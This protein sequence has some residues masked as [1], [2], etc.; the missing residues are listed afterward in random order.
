MSRKENSGKPGTSYRGNARSL[1]PSFSRG[2]GEEEITMR[3]DNRGA[4]IT[5]A[6]SGFGRATADIM[7]REGA[8]MVAVDIGQAPLDDTV[9]ASVSWKRGTTTSSWICLDCARLP[10][11]HILLPRPATAS[12]GKY[13]S[14]AAEPPPTCWSSFEA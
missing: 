12:W 7:A 11:S 4:I 5:A 9:A 10:M 13:G 2:D 14:F 1:D 6:A 3:F 8:T